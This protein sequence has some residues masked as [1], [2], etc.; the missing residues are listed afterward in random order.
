MNGKEAASSHQRQ[1][2]IALVRSLA[3]K[4][5]SIQTHTL[6]QLLFLAVKPWREVTGTVF[7]EESVIDMQWHIQ[8]GWLGGWPAFWRADDLLQ[9]SIR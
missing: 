2:Y 8:M 6:L 9:E 4:C 1:D 3:G 7:V 5:E